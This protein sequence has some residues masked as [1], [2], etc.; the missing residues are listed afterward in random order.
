MSYR[1]C[2]VCRSSTVRRSIFFGYCYLQRHYDL[3]RCRTCGFLFVD[4]LP[5]E[6]VLMEAYRSSEF[7]DEYVSPGSGSIGYLNS[8]HSSN[9][10]DEMTLALL[11]QYRCGGTLL[12]V[13]CA[14]GRFLAR[15]RGVGYE[16]FG[17]E[18]NA[19]MA[20][21]ARDVLGLKVFEGNLHSAR[22]IFG[23]SFFDVVHLA[24]VLEHLRDLHGAFDDIRYLVKPGG[25]LVLQQPMK[26][27][28]Q[29]FN[30]LLRLY[31]LT[32]KNRYYAHP[33]LH[34]W[35][36]TAATLRCVLRNM[37]FQILHFLTFESKP[38]PMQALKTCSAKKRIAY[39]VKAVSRS[40][41][42]SPLFSF[43]QLGN[44]ALVVCRKM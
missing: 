15:T 1:L 19:R 35:E 28:R 32:R 17:L 22:D 37:G 39:C 5:E 23:G 43:L 40:I 26:Y 4:P 16:V 6:D 33:P 18:P 36:F 10:Y 24:D 41:S 31:M 7:F 8:F 27:N 21:H 9:E 38:K 42:N 12:D 11:A 25:L 34:L 13:G 14:G 29:P 3:V 44:R 2:P 30:L 20:A